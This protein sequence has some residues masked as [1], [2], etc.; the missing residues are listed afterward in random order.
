MKKMF[1]LKSKKF[2]RLLDSRLSIIK[3]NYKYY[4]GSSLSIL[5]N[6]KPTVNLR[7]VIHISKLDNYSMFIRSWFLRSVQN[8][9]LFVVRK[10]LVFILFKGNRKK[11][12]QVLLNYIKFLTKSIFKFKRLA[13]RFSQE[14]TLN[15]QNSDNNIIKNEKFFFII[16]M[17]YKKLLGKKF[18]EKASYKNY[19][20][21]LSFKV[22][23]RNKKNI[24]RSFHKLPLNL[25]FRDWVKIKTNIINF[26]YLLKY[27]YL[28]LLNVKLFNVTIKIF[29][30]KMYFLSSDYILLKFYKKL[31]RHSKLIFS[32]IIRKQTKV[33]LKRSKIWLLIKQN[34]I[35]YWGF[36]ILYVLLYELNGENLGYLSGKNSFIFTKLIFNGFSNSLRFSNKWDIFGFLSLFVSFFKHYGMLFSLNFTTYV[37]TEINIKN[38]NNLLEYS[39]ARK[40]VNFSFIEKTFFLDSF[41]RFNNIFNKKAEILF[42]NANK[43]FDNFFFFSVKESRGSVSFSPFFFNLTALGPISRLLKVV[44]LRV[45]ELLSMPQRYRSYIKR[46]AWN[47][48]KLLEKKGNLNVFITNKRDNNK[49]IINYFGLNKLHDSVYVFNISNEQFFSGFFNLRR[50][51][52]TQAALNKSRLFVFVA[53]AEGLFFHKGLR[54]FYL[55]FNYGFFRGVSMPLSTVYSNVTAIKL[56]MYMLK[57]NLAKVFPRSLNRKGIKSRWMNWQDYMIF[58]Y[59]KWIRNRTTMR[60]LKVDSPNMISISNNFFDLMYKRLVGDI[61]PKF[62]TSFSVVASTS[63][64]NLFS[65]RLLTIK[66]IELYFMRLTSFLF[67]TFSSSYKK[68]TNK[69]FNLTSIKSYYLFYRLYV[70]DFLYFLNQI[71]LIS[72]IIK[73]VFIFLILYLYMIHLR[74]VLSKLLLFKCLNYSTEE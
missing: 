10:R 32:F 64:N 8:L 54:Q 9:T 63:L 57:R 16:Y 58:P 45:W 17:F 3:K 36:I 48:K 46:R 34:K 68:K 60:M 62:L 65:G 37:F 14:R 56:I 20:R 67:N 22:H 73:S 55:F 13:I 49:H 40:K 44:K 28:Y 23:Y 72:Y 53:Q 43:L 33:T 39:S 52:F 7:R 50:R 51:I 31:K 26:L 1:R 47:I 11:R 24:K 5:S 42:F 71:M 25:S 66:K 70:P 6:F 30:G 27:K 74:C 59:P 21:N 2:K 29:S 12:N 19:L 69:I 61:G 38:Y 15:V 41:Y 35:L 18:K 4:L